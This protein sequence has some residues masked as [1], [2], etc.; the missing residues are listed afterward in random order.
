MDDHSLISVGSN[1]RP[2]PSPLPLRRG[3]DKVRGSAA[4]RVPIDPP[5]LPLAKERRPTS[6]VWT[7][8]EVPLF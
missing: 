2:R 1:V 4:V 3:Q 7:M 8:L 5:L 6:R